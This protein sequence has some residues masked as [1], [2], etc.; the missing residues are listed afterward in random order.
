MQGNV[1]LS[2]LRFNDSVAIPNDDQR[3][4][5]L[6]VG[7]FPALGFGIVLTSDPTFQVPAFWTPVGPILDADVGL[8]W[9]CA[10]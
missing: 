9:R 3:S 4:S 2:Q 8:E 7:T 1:A 6:M 5:S 10:R